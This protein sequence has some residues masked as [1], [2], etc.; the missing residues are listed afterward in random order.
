MVLLMCPVSVSS[1]QRTMIEYV[2]LADVN[3][4]DECAHQLGALMHERQVVSAGH[5][6]SRDQNDMCMHYS[7]GTISCTTLTRRV[8][9]V[10][11]IIRSD[12]QPHP[13]RASN[14]SL[15]MCMTDVMRCDAL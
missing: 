3:D 9:I 12:R 10:V 5:D 14:V 1:H 4:T 11:H 2:M 13:V 7:S 8:H 6:V 15:Q